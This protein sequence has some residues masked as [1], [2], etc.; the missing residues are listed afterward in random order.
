MPQQNSA[1]NLI[2]NAYHSEQFGAQENNDRFRGEY[3]ADDIGMTDEGK[4]DASSS[5]SD[6]ESVHSRYSRGSRGSRTSRKSTGSKG[7]LSHKVIK[8]IKK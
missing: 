3:E 8:K 5:S 1:L 6:A 7:S 4:S 2:G